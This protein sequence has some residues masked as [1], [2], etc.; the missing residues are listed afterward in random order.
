MPVEP[1][2]VPEPADKPVLSVRDIAAI[3]GVSV[4]TAHR[5]VAEDTWATV[6]VRGA[7]RVPTAVFRTWEHID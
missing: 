2:A 5:M 4:R 7:R 6:D 3:L 1:T